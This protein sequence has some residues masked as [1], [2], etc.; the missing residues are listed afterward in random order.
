MARKRR[1]Y[2]S[3]GQVNKQNSL[4]AHNKGQSRVAK[5]QLDSNIFQQSNSAG[6]SSNQ[7]PNDTNAL[8]LPSDRSSNNDGNKLYHKV[9]ITKP[10]KKLTKKQRKRLEKI[11]DGKKKRAKVEDV[12]QYN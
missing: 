11:V 9:A 12:N 4:T 10:S 3:S 6:S 8:L 7:Q 2:V 5:V 1:K